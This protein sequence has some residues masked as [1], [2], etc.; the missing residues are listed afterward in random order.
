MVFT[1]FDEKLC[2][3]EKS[4]IL[5]K[6]GDKNSNHKTR[7]QGKPRARIDGNREFRG[8]TK[9]LADIWCV[10]AYAIFR[11]RVY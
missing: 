8:Y 1:L 2:H 6:T 3:N 4:Q 5:R 7:A 9:V 11:S 10:K